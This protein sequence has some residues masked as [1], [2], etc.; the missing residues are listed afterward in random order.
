MPPI[1]SQSFCVSVPWDME[2][3]V[4]KSVLDTCRDKW[5]LRKGREN[6]DYSWEVSSGSVLH[7]AVI[8]AQ[9]WNTGVVLSHHCSSQLPRAIHEQKKSAAAGRTNGTKSSLISIKSKVLNHYKRDDLENSL[10]VSKSTSSLL[11][12]AH[13][14]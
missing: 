12:S 9:G 11:Q 10:D 8:P 6:T 4:I 7:S 1:S 5:V 3:H 13:R 2:L 14:D